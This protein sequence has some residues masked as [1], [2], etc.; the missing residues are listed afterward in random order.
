MVD[1]LVYYLFLGTVG[2]LRLCP[3]RVQLYLFYGIGQL[4]LWC[5]PRY[6]KIAHKNLQLA[7]PEASVEERRG[8]IKRHLWVLGQLLVDFLRLSRRDEDW[9]DENVEFDMPPSIQ[10]AMKRGES[11][12]FLAGHLGSFEMVPPAFLNRFGEM[13]YVVR[14]M[15]NPHLDRW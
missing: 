5:K 7:F 8:I 12:L 9:F 1:L 4:V 10:A 2:F 6:Q 3:A 13:V 11:V 15:K 14:S